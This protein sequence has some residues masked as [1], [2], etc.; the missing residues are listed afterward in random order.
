VREK[1]DEVK[2]KVS[3]QGS[4]FNIQHCIYVGRAHRPHAL[5]QMDYAAKHAQ[6]GAGGWR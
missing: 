5:F 4:K 1:V 2:T 6:R 3:D